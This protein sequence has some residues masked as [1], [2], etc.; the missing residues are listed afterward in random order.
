MRD[1]PLVR[2]SLRG[3]LLTLVICIASACSWMQERAEAADSKRIRD[4]AFAKFD[5][6]QCKASGGK[7]QGVCMFGLPACVR[8]YSDA[9]KICTDKSDC[10]G[11]CVQ[12][13]PWALA[14]AKTT[15]VREVSNDPCGCQSVVVA[16]MATKGVC[17]D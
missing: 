6:A 11:Q 16:G 8:Q 17:W 3:A 14:G 15:G 1:V 9:G 12:K 10:E 4:E 13:E 5:T 2:L 7:V